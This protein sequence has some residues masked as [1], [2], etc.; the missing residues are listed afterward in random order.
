MIAVA[1][2]NL[3]SLS[4]PVGAVFVNGV[5]GDG[6]KVVA[7][8]V[9]SVKR[10]SVGRR[11]KFLAL[12][13]SSLKVNRDIYKQGRAFPKVCQGGHEYRANKNEQN[14]AHKLQISVAQR[15]ILRP[16]KSTFNAYIC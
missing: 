1:W 4:L 5:A 16:S 13:W 8:M 11:L 12:D 6:S 10:R 9:N 15:L 14:M 2:G 3:A 7:F